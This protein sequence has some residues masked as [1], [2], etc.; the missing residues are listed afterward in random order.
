MIMYIAIGI[1]ILLGLVILNLEH[2][3][4]K[5]KII[6]IVLLSLMIYFSIIGVLNSDKVSLN[7]PRGIVNA[8]YY[9]FGWLG[10]TVGNLWQIGGDTVT[11]V[12]NV[13]KFNQT[14]YEDGRQ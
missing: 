8:V 11:A 6:V 10:Q 12:G 5:I 4:R 7:S 3:T 2:H 13:V 9:Y 1:L 14:E